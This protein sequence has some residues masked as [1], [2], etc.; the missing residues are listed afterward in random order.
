MLID[1]KE[2]GC[3]F[4]EQHALNIEK[5]AAI[6]HNER[7]VAVRSGQAAPKYDGKYLADWKYA[8]SQLH[9]EAKK[10][11]DDDFVDK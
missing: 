2:S 9:E 10:T 4:T 1:G 8:V 7:L 6:I 11:L 5:L 3:L